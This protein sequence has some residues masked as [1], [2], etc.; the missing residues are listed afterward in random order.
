[1]NVRSGWFFVP[2]LIAASGFF[3]VL[4]FPSFGR[5]QEI[6]WDRVMNAQPDRLTSAQRKRAEEAMKTINNYYGC[7]RSVAHCLISDPDNETARRV[8]GFIVRMAAFDRTVEQIR[9]HVTDRSRSVHPFKINKIQTRADHC[10]GDPKTA[11][12]NV[13]VFADVLCPFCSKVTPILQKLVNTRGKDF[14]MCFKHFPTLAHEK[15]GVL[16]GEAVAAAALQGK[17]YEM[18][19]LAYQHRRGINER[20]LLELARELKLDMERFEKDRSSRVI[21]RLVASDKR[22]GLQLGIRSTPHVFVNGKDYLGRK[23]E[24]ELADRLDEEIMLVRGRK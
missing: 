23:D 14:S 21:R 24:P 16:S 15:I 3:P 11:K 5:A 18:L 22:E 7:S 19:T 6:R 10:I 17:F 13:V 8:A 1:M 20:K 2:L 12:V 9:V 4:F